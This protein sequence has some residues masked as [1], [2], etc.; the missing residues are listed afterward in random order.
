MQASNATEQFTVTSSIEGMQR[1]LHAHLDDGAHPLDAI[2]VNAA[3][4][5]ISALT[6]IEP[7]PWA[8]AWLAAADEFAQEAERCERAGAPAEAREAW[9]Q[10]YRFSFVARFPAPMHPAKVEAYDV[11]REYF[12][13]AVSLDEPPIER[14]EV[15]IEDPNREGR[16][17]VPFYVAH[18]LCRTIAPP[19]VV[20]VFGGI[21]MWKEET[22]VR[23]ADLR[24]RGVATVHVDIPGV[25]ESPLL[26]GVDAERMWTPVIDWISSSNFDSD[27]LG[28]LG[29]S[30][31]GYWATKLAHTHCDRV[32]AAVNWGGGVHHTFQPAW[33]ERSR[34]AT[35]SIMELHAARAR[36]FAGRTFEDWLAG[37]AELSLVD[38][39]V[40]DLSSSPLL[41][42]NGQDDRQSD[43]TDILLALEHGDP[44]TVR[45]F[46]GG[47]MG[48]GPVGATV[49]DWMVSQ[50]S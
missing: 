23:T 38:Q 8:H 49:T 42:I 24:A 33:Q 21:D 45:L 28:V 36:I 3:R 43:A 10:A 6:S 13:K 9:W 41:L 11:S 4:S 7:G 44:K 39:G 16:G 34:V 32:R 37:C 18:P 29:L 46:P 1:W 47:H 5:V 25:G 48:T 27:R 19:P 17:D 2:D 35:S 50:L 30:F 14:V 31:G 15:T 12:L 40:L 20:I 22:Y 26:A